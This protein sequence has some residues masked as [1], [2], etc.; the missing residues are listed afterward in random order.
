[1]GFLTDDGIIYKKIVNGEEITVVSNYR[2]DNII[3]N[4]KIYTIKDFVKNYKIITGEDADFTIY[5]G[6][7]YVDWGFNS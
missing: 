7:N 5:N 4:M 2:Y 6:M 1:M 3:C